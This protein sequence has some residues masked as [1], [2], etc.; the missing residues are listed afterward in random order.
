MLSKTVGKESP[1]Q[2]NSESVVAT[3][4]QDE[5]K[6]IEL[7]LDSQNSMALILFTTQVNDINSFEELPL[8]FAQL[9]YDSKAMSEKVIQ[10]FSNLICS[11][12]FPFS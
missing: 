5:I 9:C 11:N 10:A 12:D 7:L 6:I 8:M 2:L 4:S 1:F 3:I